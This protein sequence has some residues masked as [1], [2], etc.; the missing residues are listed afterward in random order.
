MSSI[1]MSLGACRYRS[2]GLPNLSSPAG[3]VGGGA[4]HPGGYHAGLL[5]VLQDRLRSNPSVAKNFSIFSYNVVCPLLHIYVVY[6]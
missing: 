4:P 5:Y 1:T 2:E 3:S 6:G